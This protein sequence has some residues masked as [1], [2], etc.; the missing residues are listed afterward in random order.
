MRLSGVVLLLLAVFHLMWM[1]LYIGLDNITFETIV[2]RWSGPL[3]PF[4]RLYDLA[5]LVFALTHGMNGMRMIIDDY[6]RSRGWR[7]A[8][9]SLLGLIYVLLM[10]AGSYVI[11]T[12]E[13]SV[14]VLR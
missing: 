2:E 4:W 14:M 6:V 3:G 9:Q 12:F 13:T 5:L 1:H 8:V 11:F 7:V 10:M